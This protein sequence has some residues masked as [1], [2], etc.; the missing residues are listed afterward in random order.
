[1]AYRAKSR[2]R[3]EDGARRGI[4]HGRSLRKTAVREEAQEGPQASGRGC[5]SGR[6][7]SQSIKKDLL[8][9]VSIEDSAVRLRP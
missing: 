6:G 1:M 7:G 3:W 5:D 8:G 9:S 2:L 4:P